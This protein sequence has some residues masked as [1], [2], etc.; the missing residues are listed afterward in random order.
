[1]S[2]VATVA[3]VGGFQRGK[4]TFVNALL[5][6]DVAEMG[7]GLSTTHENRTYALSQGLCVIDTPGFNANGKDDEMA[8]EAIGMA[9]VVACVQ[10]SKT[11][12]SSCDE[13]F[14][15]VRKQGKRVVF[16][17][18]CCKF[19]KWSPEENGEVVATIEAELETKR[20]LPS[21]IPIAG[22]PV[23]P[24]NVLWARFGLGQT[25]DQ[26]D[27]ERVLFYANRRLRLPAEIDDVA[28]RAEMLRRSGFLPVRDFLKNLPLEILKHVAVNPKREIERVVDRFAE[29]LKKR[30]AAA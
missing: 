29:E 8:S 21:V 28:L 17:L 16:L 20:I 22:K 25:I 1:M 24:I 27:Y 13:I 2:A 4:S 7:Q 26:D 6:Q 18:N 5:G 11:I 12:G 23:F 30:W 14:E 15:L 9:D 19:A 10:E 3:I